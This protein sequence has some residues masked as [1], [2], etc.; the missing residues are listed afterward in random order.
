MF[1]TIQKQFN[2]YY[3]YIHFLYTY[4]MEQETIVIA[5]LAACSI[6]SLILGAY[7]TKSKDNDAEDEKGRQN[8]SI[9]TENVR[10]N[11]VKSS[12][13][14]NVK[15]KKTKAQKQQTP[16]AKGKK[17]ANNNKKKNNNNSDNDNSSSNSSKN[18][19][20][21]NKKEKKKKQVVV[22]KIN[23][24]VTAEEINFNEDEWETITPQGKSPKRNK[25]KEEE[26]KDKSLSPQRKILSELKKKSE[27]KGTVFVPIN[28][29]NIGR[30]VGKAGANVKRI[31]KET[32]A[33]VSVNSDKP[34]SPQILIKGFPKQIEAAKLQIEASIKKGDA[35]KKEPVDY[36]ASDKLNLKTAQN[37][38]SLIGPKGATIRKL[39]SD[40]GAVFA[41]DRDTNTVTIS[42][43]KASVAKG[44]EMVK[45]LLASLNY[46]RVI[47]ISRDDVGAVLGKKGTRIQ[48]MEKKAKA[49][50][51]VIRN[52]DFCKVTV[53]GLKDNV[54]HAEKLI[55]KAL[56][57]ASNPMYEVKEG[58]VVEERELGTAV[59]TVIGQ[60]GKNIHKIKDESKTRIRIAKKATKCFVIGTPENVKKAMEMIDE[61]IARYDKF[62]EKKKKNEEKD[63][64]DDKVD[65]ELEEGEIR[66]DKDGEYPIKPS[67]SGNWADM[68]D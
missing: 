55:K 7:C 60:K 20:S 10:K 29:S 41:V 57:N 17:N 35:G 36:E 37:R 47:D 26:K 52:D 49:R 63:V 68:E 54:L 8:G 11:P 38:S 46:E 34:D 22:E 48:E 30:L 28:A 61:T 66:E 3:I 53:T 15:K 39:E 4:N 14:K 24:E 19:K 23:A 25:K 33:R 13:S 21:N 18:K 40:S 9:V 12:K 65:D 64:V 67:T 56:E 43:T 1:I 6:G 50:I 5:T 45:S 2:R 27:E 51:K 44:M 59:S 16:K 31:E 42:G 58:E 32:G 62:L